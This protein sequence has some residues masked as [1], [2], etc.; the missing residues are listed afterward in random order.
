MINYRGLNIPHVVMGRVTSDNLFDPNEQVIFDFY[1]ANQFRYKRAADV[2][3]NIGVHSILMAR[4]GWNVRAYE[5]ES[6]HFFHLCKNIQSHGVA[7]RVVPFQAAVSNEEGT[8]DFV[9]VVNNTTSSHIAGAKIYY[10]P[11]ERFSVGAV[12]FRAIHEWADFVKIDCEGHEAALI[13]SVNWCAWPRSGTRTDA[14]VEVGSPETAER[15]CDYLLFAC[16]MWAQKID[17]RRVESIRDV[18]KHH[19]EGSLF[20]GRDPPFISGMFA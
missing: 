13:E 8:V 17:W 1:E 3:A 20:I 14:M 12:D 6:Y 16:P 2:G 4:A 11:V 10:G 19:S 7:D 9:R 18:P 5:P 15:I